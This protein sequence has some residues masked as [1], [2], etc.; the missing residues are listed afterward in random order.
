MATTELIEL[1]IE[2]SKKRLRSLL[3]FSDWR[4]FGSQGREVSIQGLTLK[5]LATP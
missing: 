2:T 1:A 3:T 5:T 4:C